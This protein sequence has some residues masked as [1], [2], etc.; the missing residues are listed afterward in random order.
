MPRRPFLLL[1]LV[2]LFAWSG[3]VARGGLAYDDREVLEGNPA[4]EG[5]VGWT[6]V[7]LRD[8]WDHLPGGAA[9][10]YRPLATA[11]LRLDH[12]AHGARPWAL[13]A[14]NV[15]LHLGVVLAAA[16]LFRLRGRRLPLVGLAVFAA[17]P[18]LADSVAWIS[19]RTSMVS[20]LGGLAGGLVVARCARRGEAPGGKL[21]T[22]LCTALGAALAVLL[23]TL[24]KEDGIVFGVLAVALAL[25]RGRRPALAAIGGAVLGLVAYLGLRAAALGNAWPGS[26]H[27]PLDGV[28]LLERLRIAGG[29]GLEALRVALLPVHYPPAWEL[30]DLADT[31]ALAALLAWTLLALALVAGL[32]RPRCDALAG[33]ALAAVAVLP[34]SQLVPSGELLAP[35][36][37]YLPLLFAAPAVH[38]LWRETGARTTPVVLV[39]AACVAL[40]WTRAGVYASRASYWEARATWRETPRTF[41][42]LGNARLEQ[43]D[44]E[45]AAEAWRAALELD[46]GYSR[47]WVNLATLAMRREDWE[48]AEELL[49]TALR[50]NPENP[51][52]WGNLGRVRRER[53]RQEQAA[54]AYERA[55]E[56]SPRAAVFWRG[57]TRARRDAG[58]AEGARAAAREAARLD[59]EGARKLLE[60]LDG[61]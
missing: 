18:A 23:A 28:S 14:T 43:G 7:L 35:R 27:A 45:G 3:A 20:A 17:H 26:P 30:A 49:A 9:G 10:H 32:A 33:L 2:V 46:P 34:V 8:Y 41:N 36:F 6:E 56:L 53:G 22:E 24:G 60:T 25:E 1:T 48:R 52:A 19:G 59:P 31:G 21:G 55:I 37:L 61:D 58:D 47:P 29:A 39:L 16:A 57:L 54:R 15:L 38:A 12:A 11:T 51:V 5:S 13:H 4:V 50:A 42:A 44:V 40:A